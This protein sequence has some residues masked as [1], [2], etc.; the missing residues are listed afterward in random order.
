[1]T[2]TFCMQMHSELLTGINRHSVNQLH[3]L[4]SNR[5]INTQWVN[6]IGS[7]SLSTT[8]QDKHVL[9]PIGYYIYILASATM[10][11]AKTEYT[12]S[13]PI[14]NR[15]ISYWRQCLILGNWLSYKHKPNNLLLDI[16][17]HQSIKDISL[18]YNPH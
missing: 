13:A 7:E 8:N 2:Q 14:G 18:Q 12:V 11:K 1:M 5:S 4:C 16:P 17:D 6:T 9:F 3:I 10:N 15:T